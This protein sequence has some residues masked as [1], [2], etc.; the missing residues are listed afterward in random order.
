MPETPFEQWQRYRRA[1]G[2]QALPAAL[3]D[4]DALDENLERLLAPVRQAA[5]TLRV[6][7]KS[8]RC[9]ALLRHLQARA[10]GALRGLMTYTAAETAW[11]AQEGFRELLLAYP[12]AHPE[13]ARL[14]ATASATG[15]G[16]SVVADAPEQLAVLS[17]AAREA[18]TLL[19]VVV[20]LD[21]S[22]RPLGS[23][24][25]LGA[26]RSPLHTIAA[27]VAF[28]QR[29]ARTP[30][31]RF[32]GVLAYEAH[33]AGLPDHSP[34][35]RAQN[36]PKRLLKRLARGPVERARAELV[37]ALHAAGLPPKVVN[38][39]GSSNLGWCCREPALTE[40]TAGS[41]FLGS[42]LFDYFAD[43]D[44]VPAAFFALQ[45][46]RRP[47]PGI[48][49]CHGGGFVASGAAGEDRLP[50]PALPAG[51][52]LLPAEGAGEVQTPLRHDPSVNLALGDP[53]FF[54][55]AKAGELAEHVREYLLVRGDRI[56]DRVPTYRG[57][58]Q[59]FLG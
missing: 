28:A 14:L 15:V 9:P 43:L 5:K 6:A 18:N 54:R 47:A 33:I 37:A 55:H 49:T 53:V 58:G 25:H 21:V 30:R 51:L 44:V 39:G 2:A 10:G 22:L 42:H 7:T 56:V 31:L 34:F 38:G 23:L 19:D 36:L 40:V 59:C 20:E 32:H 11:L 17:T 3:V 13:D 12:T 8:I 45:V 27:A 48:V 1:L 50:R 4:L 57:L 46:V 35:A 41:G 29:V 26:R 16:V 52:A 24:L